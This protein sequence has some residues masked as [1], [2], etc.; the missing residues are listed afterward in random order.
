MEGARDRLEREERDAIRHAWMT[1]KLMR[2]RDVPDL[3]QLIRPQPKVQSPVELQAMFDAMAV[4]FGAVKQE[5]S[6]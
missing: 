3:D 6:A 4:A 5:G 2:A 1:A